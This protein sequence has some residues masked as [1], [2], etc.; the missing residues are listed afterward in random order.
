MA[1]RNEDKVVLRI[2]VAWTYIDMKE[3]SLV[4]V[5]AEFEE[6]KL[7]FSVHL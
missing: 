6:I 2:E 3:G 1:E 7:I 5:S 4:L